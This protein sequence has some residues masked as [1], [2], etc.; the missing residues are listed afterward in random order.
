MKTT[1]ICYISFCCISLLLGCSNCSFQP[2]NSEDLVSEAL[3]HSRFFAYI[4]SVSKNSFFTIENE[5][6]DYIEVSVGAS[7]PDRFESL[8]TVRILKTNGRVLKLDYD[9]DGE[10]VWIDDT[11]KEGEKL[12]ER[13]SQK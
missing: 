11:F 8:G 6:R 10:A 3:L 5:N 13:N 12:P 1:R 2:K 4:R 9:K 7:T